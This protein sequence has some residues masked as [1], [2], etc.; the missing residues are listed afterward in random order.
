MCRRAP[1]KKFHV[2]ALIRISESAKADRDS[3]R[4]GEAPAFASLDCGCADA[5]LQTAGEATQAA[6]CPPVLS[7]A[8]SLECATTT[9]F[10]PNRFAS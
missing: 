1:R 7:G 10:L 5:S 3:K 6:R 9:R 8:T 2:L 4:P